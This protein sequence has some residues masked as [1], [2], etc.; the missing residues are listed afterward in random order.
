[1]DK[2]PTALVLGLAASGEAAARLLL[3]EGTQVRVVDRNDGDDLRR[4][5]S[6]LKALGA[7]VILG[8][9]A[10][11]PDPYAVCVVSPGIP[12]NSDW[13]RAV[14]GRGIPVIPE[15]ELGWSRACPS[16]ASGRRGAAC[17]V[18]AVSG[19]N[20]KST[21]VKLC[22]EA[23][24]CA[25][26]RVAVAG[27]YGPPVSRVAL[28][29]MDLDWMVL[30]VSSFQLETARCFRP[31]VAV[32]VNLFPNHLDRHGDMAEYARLKSRLF[33]RMRPRDVGIVPEGD[34]ASMVRLAASS[35]RWVTF[36][37]S[38]SADVRYQAGIVADRARSW[39]VSLAGTEFD[40]EVMGLT[41]AAAVAAISACGEA[42]DALLQAV[43]SFQP[44]PHRMQEVAV[45]RQIR[46][47]DDSKATNLAALLAALKMTSRP[48][49][50]IA[51]GLPKHESYAEARQLLAEKAA[52]VYLI[53][54]AAESMAAAWRDGVP[55]RMSGTLE[56][57]V[58]AAWAEAGPGETILLAPACASFDQFHSFEERGRCFAD[59][60]RSLQV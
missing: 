27:N 57:A 49:R 18:L 36:G 29:V 44:L 53:G 38:P 40:N 42:P 3:A 45:L 5:A 10:L 15:L 33:A 60:V 6:A 21:L 2:Y 46:F 48:V 47:V 11:P 22:G 26:R 35:N 32:L 39:S 59:L 52:A 20:G 25:G 28:E 14:N 34:A 17:R 8:S 19:S 24:A 58:R 51:G 30:E 50:L 7:Q 41:A 37:I 54:T 16:E 9:S 1:M 55:C 4:R 31:D 56:E 23:L 43:R 12:A 13:V